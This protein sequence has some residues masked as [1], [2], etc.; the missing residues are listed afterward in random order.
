ML[1]DLRRIK[2]GIEGATLIYSMWQGY[3]EEDRMRRFRKFVDEMSMTMVSLHT[4]GHADIDTLKEVVDTV[5]PKTIIPI[6][7]FKP[8]LYEDLF[9]NVLRAEDRKAITI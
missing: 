6:H 7:T 3:L 9:P 4:G 1:V 5:K 2:E 8:D